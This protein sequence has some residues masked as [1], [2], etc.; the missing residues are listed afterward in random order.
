MPKNE[1]VLYDV[2]RINRLEGFSPQAATQRALDTIL[3]R[4]ATLESPYT[5]TVVTNRHNDTLEVVARTWQGTVKEPVEK[6]L[7]GRWPP[8]VYSLS[9]VAIPFPPD[10]PYYGDGRQAAATGIPPLGSLHLR[11]ERGTLAV[12]IQ[13]LMRL[14]HN[15]FFDHMAKRIVEF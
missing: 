1:L 9:H 4:R 11:G 13:Q 15:P 5:L 2:N 7:R 8:E 14:R 6:P 10:D 3:S 12:P